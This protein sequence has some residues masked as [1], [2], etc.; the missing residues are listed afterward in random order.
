[1]A[2]YTLLTSLSDWVDFMCAIGLVATLHLLLYP[3]YRKEYVLERTQ[4]TSSVLT[5]TSMVLTAIIQACGGVPAATAIRV[6]RLAFLAAYT[7]DTLILAIKR[8]DYNVPFH[9]FY[10]VHHLGALFIIVPYMMLWGSNPDL[11]HLRFLVIYC[12]E[13]QMTEAAIAWRYSCGKPTWWDTNPWRLFMA[14]DC[15]IPPMVALVYSVACSQGSKM[16]LP[17]SHPASIYGLITCC[18]IIPAIQLYYH[19]KSW[20]AKA[21]SGRMGRGLQ[22]APASEP[23]AAPEGTGGQAV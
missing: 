4:L 23:T 9:K 2:L 14:L 6:I 1:M 17:A 11:V 18:F 10:F 19:Y 8:R 22:A 3:L 5:S 16:V 7:H 21:R 13:S 12:C 20:A 15:T